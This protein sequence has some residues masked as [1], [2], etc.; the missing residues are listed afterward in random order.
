MTDPK[1]PGGPFGHNPAMHGHGCPGCDAE[2][3]RVFAKHFGPAPDRDSPEAVQARKDQP[4]PLVMYL[5]VRESLEMG[6]GKI[7]AQCGHAVGMAIIEYYRVKDEPLRVNDVALMKM[8]LDTSYRKVVLRAD[9]KEWE[10]LK[11]CADVLS[12]VVV[13]AGLTEV[14][15]GSETVMALWPMFRSSAPKLVR[16]LQVL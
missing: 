10:K 16:R 13:D 7:G 5:V 14:A 12:F 15:A 4:D 1:C 6:A 2:H 3:E 8:W 9:D 11:A